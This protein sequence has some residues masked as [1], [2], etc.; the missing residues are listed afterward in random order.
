ME[1]SEDNIAHAID[2]WLNCI[3]KGFVHEFA[4][5]TLIRYRE[6]DR[7][8]FRG[9]RDKYLKYLNSWIKILLYEKQVM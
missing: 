6:A 3:I 1:V 8:F 5:D 2:H 7:C 4:I 9:L